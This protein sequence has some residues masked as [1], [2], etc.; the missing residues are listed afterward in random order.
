MLGLSWGTQG[1]CCIMQDLLLWFL[2]SLVVAHGLSSL[3][4][5]FICSTACGI[6]VPQPGLEPVSPTLQHRFLSTEP[7]RKSL[8]SVIFFFTSFLTGYLFHPLASCHIPGAWHSRCSR[9]ICWLRRNEEVGC[10][11]REGRRLEIFLTCPSPTPRNPWCPATR[12]GN[13]FESQ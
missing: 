4:Q 12:H 11:G 3:A 1:L 5:G 9:N 7:A 8:Q 2:D 10:V 13:H 6:L